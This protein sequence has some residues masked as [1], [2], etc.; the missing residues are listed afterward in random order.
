MLPLALVPVAEIIAGL[1]GAVVVHKIMPK[2]IAIDV[3]FN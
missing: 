3:E 2:R 1:A